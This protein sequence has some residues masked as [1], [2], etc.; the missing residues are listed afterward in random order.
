MKNWFTEGLC[1]GNSIS[2][3]VSIIWTTGSLWG[4]KYI[5]VKRVN[6]EG[7]VPLESGHSL[8]LY[9]PNQRVWTHTRVEGTYRTKDSF[10]SFIHSW[11]IYLTQ[12]GWLKSGK[13]LV[14]CVRVV[15]FLPECEESGPCPPFHSLLLLVQQSQT[16]S[17][18]F[19]TRACAESA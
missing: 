9:G 6:K 19:F 4:N 8:D 13:M 17:N 1:C 10:V 11:G 5:K 15:L 12:Q 18:I 7:K 2:K 16:M 14:C 3:E